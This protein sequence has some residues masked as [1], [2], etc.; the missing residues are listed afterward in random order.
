MSLLSDLMVRGFHEESFTKVERLPELSEEPVAIKCY[1]IAEGFFRDATER[2]GSFSLSEGIYAKLV[3]LPT[4]PP[5]H[6]TWLEWGLPLD[7]REA[8]KQHYAYL[9]DGVMLVD[10]DDWFSASYFCQNPQGGA[11]HLIAACE[12]DSGPGNFE[13]RFRNGWVSP[14]GE[15]MAR[16]MFRDV[17]WTAI[18]QED[19]ESWNMAT[20]CARYMTAVGMLYIMDV[21]LRMMHVKNVELAEVPVKKRKKQRRIRPDEQIKWNTIRVRPQGKQYAN[22]TAS[23]LPTMTAHHVVRGHFAQ[24]TADKPLFG[25]YVGTFWRDAHTRGDKTAGEVAKDYTITPEEEAA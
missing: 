21:S 24:Y 12:L 10:R 7:M 3:D 20:K 1:E 6:I 13:K 25:K 4:R 23:G 18:G 15:A 22:A 19:W 11:P 2:G 17:N 5:F 8:A 9:V 14:V 16:G